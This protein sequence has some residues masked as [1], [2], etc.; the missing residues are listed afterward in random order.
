MIGLFNYLFCALSI[1]KQMKYKTDYFI[2]SL[3][4]D[5]MDSKLFINRKPLKS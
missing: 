5:Y 2:S 3:K 1:S 4:M